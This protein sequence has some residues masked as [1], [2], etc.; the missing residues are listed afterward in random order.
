MEPWEVA[1]WIE[2]NSWLHTH[3]VVRRVKPWPRLFESILREFRS[4]K[5]K[6]SIMHVE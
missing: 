1:S 2:K 5:F 3:K 6:K 4:K